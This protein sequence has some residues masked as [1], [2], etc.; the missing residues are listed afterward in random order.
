MEVCLRNFIWRAVTDSPRVMANLVK[1]KV[2][3]S[4]LCP[5]CGSV[6]E[7]VEHMFFFCGHATTTWFMSSWGY[8]PARLDSPALHFDAMKAWLRLVGLSN[9][10]VLTPKWGRSCAA[11]SLQVCK[12]GWLQQSLL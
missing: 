8:K 1:R 9:F 4:A 12:G 6:E 5:L 11:R 10:A 7:T 2:H 3:V